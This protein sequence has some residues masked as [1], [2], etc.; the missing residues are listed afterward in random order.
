MLGKIE[1]R[2]EGPEDEV[3]GWHHRSSEHDLGQTPGDG[4]GQGVRDREAWRVQAMGLQRGGHD[5]PTG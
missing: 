1:G 4:E 2:E 5:W 3:A